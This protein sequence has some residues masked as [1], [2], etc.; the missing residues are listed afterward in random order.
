[1]NNKVWWHSKTLW[2]NAIAAALVAAES[3]TG[4]LQPHVGVNLYAAIAVILPIANSF[5]RV[6]T[7]KALTS[8]KDV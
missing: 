4:M 1:M 6:I 8:D 3:V 2:F 5:L 7:T